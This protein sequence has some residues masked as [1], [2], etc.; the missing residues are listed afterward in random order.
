MDLKNR[1][2]QYYSNSYLNSPKMKSNLSKSLVKYRHSNFKLVILEYCLK[3]KDILSQEQYFLDLLKP[4]YNILKVA[5]SPLGSKHTEETNALMSALKLGIKKSEQHK[6]SMSHSNPNKITIEVTDLE[7]NI[8]TTYHSIHAAARHLGFRQ[9]II[10]MYFKRNQIK[11][12]K[13]R[14]IFTKL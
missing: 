14:Y 8:S 4:E 12:F 7:T 11:L 2:R 9:S 10:S 5:G 3:K 1:L 6:L 13:G